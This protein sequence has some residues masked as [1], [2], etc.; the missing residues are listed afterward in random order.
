MRRVLHFIWKNLLHISSYEALRGRDWN[1][2]W[3]H[4]MH[5]CESAK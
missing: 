4:Y 5:V 2:L 3:T 1:F